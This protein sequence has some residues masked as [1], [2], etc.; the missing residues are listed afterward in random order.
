LHCAVQ[1]RM[2]LFLIFFLSSFSCLGDDVEIGI[3]RNNKK[4]RRPKASLLPCQGAE[5][6]LHSFVVT[7]GVRATACLNN[8]LSFNKS[9]RFCSSSFKE[10]QGL[11]SSNAHETAISAVALKVFVLLDSRCW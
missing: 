6:Y 1:P 11:I 3:D 2:A 5:L 9:P 4:T 8:I 10:D 7:P